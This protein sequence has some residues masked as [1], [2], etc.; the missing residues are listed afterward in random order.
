MLSN[1]EKNIVDKIQDNEIQFGQPGFFNNTKVAVGKKLGCFDI[2][3]NIK[4]F[5]AILMD[6]NATFKPALTI[7]DNAVSEHFRNMKTRILT[8]SGEDDVYNFLKFNAGVN[9]AVRFERQDL[10]DFMKQVKIIKNI[11]GDQH[12]IY[13]PGFNGDGD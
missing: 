8:S 1:N 5:Q 7:N 3:D 2:F 13:K 11:G 12:L 10:I 6:D 9:H 4:R